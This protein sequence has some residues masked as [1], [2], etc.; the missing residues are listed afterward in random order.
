MTSKFIFSMLYFKNLHSVGD[1][2]W[3]FSIRCLFLILF[4]A[5]N[6]RLLLYLCKNQIGS[7]NATRLIKIQ[8]ILDITT[9]AF[10]PLFQFEEDFSNSYL[11]IYYLYF[12][13]YVWLNNN[14]S[15]YF[16]MC[17]QFVMILISFERFVCI[18]FPFHYKFITPL[19]TYLAFLATCFYCIVFII[20]EL[21]EIVFESVTTNS[22]GTT[23]ICK[24]NYSIIENIIICFFLYM[25]P[26]FILLIFNIIPSIVLL[27]NI[28]NKI[29]RNSNLKPF[30]RKNLFV[31]FSIANFISSA[32]YGVLIS[33]VFLFIITLWNISIS[34]DN[35]FYYFPHFNSVLTVVNP[36]VYII[37]FKKVRQFFVCL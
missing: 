26:F 22:T 31:R 33:L 24:Y 37:L 36:I 32:F 21:K 4:I 15:W 10:L 5:L 16:S 7:V 35:L 6:I 29:T 12:Y 23:Q 2:I 18:V 17:S 3:F 8:T 34:P 28:K 13:C 25:I 20:I 1:N 19:R 14:L 27:K 9:I 30:G 11:N